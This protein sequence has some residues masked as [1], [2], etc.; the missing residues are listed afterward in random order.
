VRKVII[1]LAFLAA[2][3]SGSSTASTSVAP[4]PAIAGSTT[5]AASPREAVQAFMAAIKVGDLQ[6]M[7]VVFGTQDG[8]LR[9]H[10]S[11]EELDQREVITQRCLRHDSY[12]VLG[13]TPSA[14]GTR[15][16]SVQVVLKDLTA[17]TDFTLAQGPNGRWYVSML[18][19]NNMQKICTA[20]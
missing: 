9:D 10:V 17:A 14:Q 19:L 1:G 7:S 5:G 20:R 11:R 3:G 15:T 6:A 4:T 18:D 13:E 16:I 8:L 12:K 2:C